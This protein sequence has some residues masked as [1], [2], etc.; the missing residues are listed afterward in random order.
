M[1]F[2]FTI[3][4]GTF[5]GGAAMI[6]PAIA[7]AQ[8]NEPRR[9]IVVTGR[10]LGDTPAVPAYR[11]TQIERDQLT[12]SSS[13]RIEEVLANVAGFQ[14]FRRSDSRSANASAQGVT[15]RAIGGNAT[16]RALVLLD[17]VPMAHPFFGYVPFSA[18]PPDR[19]SRVRVTHG[20]GAGAFGAGAVSGTIELTSA[21]LESLDPLSAAA[22][23]NDR[24][25]TELS[26]IAAPRLGGGFA[27]IGAQ[28][29]RGKGFYTTPASQRVPQTARARFDSWSTSLRAVAPLN[30]TTELQFGA[31]LFDDHRTLRFNGAHSTSSGQDASV[32]LVSRGDWQIDALAYVQA[33][34]FSNI[35]ISATQFRP[36]LDQRDT[37]STGYGG[38]LELRPPV[39]GDHVLRF[40]ADLRV[41]DGRME[42]EAF[43]AASGARTAIRRA[44]GQTSD[45]GLFVEDDWTLG[46]LILTAGARADRWTVR[47]GVFS[48]QNGSG[49][50]TTSRRFEDRSG[51]DGSFRGGVLWRAT[52]SF[53]LRGAAYTSLRQ[54]TLNELYR[55][56]AVFPVTT[57][58]N[59]ELRNEKLEGFE[60]GI[61]F[62]AGNALSLSLTAFDNRL[63]H[64]IANVTIS[65]NLRERQNV[66]AI[67]A[68]GIELAGEAL[69]GP[70]SFIGSLA[71]T[72]SKV[73]ASG[74]SVP[75]NGMRPAQ[76]PAFAAS[77]TLSWQPRLG[78][79]LSAT[80]R[81]VGMQYEDDLQSDVLPAATTLDAF[82]EA[83]INGRFSLILRGENLTNERVVTRNQDGSL[84]LGVPATVWAGVKLRLPR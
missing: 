82:A 73:R 24:G 66:D 60:A 18:I 45:L 83:P 62:R 38:K 26:A 9:E 79:R 65:Q 52:D 54:P 23:V 56:F 21:G 70:I 31:L 63:M 11:A 64:A 67:R 1:S 19:L 77:G 48:E 68:R 58:A 30:E 12:S 22:L 84:D 80:L 17:G 10:G 69:L 43:N 50:L 20:G 51:W 29:D 57:Q 28:W 5:A 36:V 25:E 16:S 34:D 40:G 37:P 49:V 46:R 14:Q 42:E 4:L 76:V 35:V 8:D 72:D 15:L 71:A 74:A 13:G 55:P 75:L 2:R 27:V 53:A 41:A 44:G 78:W 6:A 33:R 47:D 81:H 39:G 61:D 59:A 7:Q 3:W 32:R